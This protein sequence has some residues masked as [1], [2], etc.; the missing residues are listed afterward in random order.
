MLGSR[1]SSTGGSPTVR[2]PVL[3]RGHLVPG[4]IRKSVRT[5]FEH[6]PAHTRGHPAPHRGTARKVPSA[7]TTS[8]GCSGGSAHCRRQCPRLVDPLSEARRA[9]S[10]SGPGERRRRTHS[11]C[12]SRGAMLRPVR[13]E[14]RYAGSE[15]D[16]SVVAAGAVPQREP[17]RDQPVDLPRQPRHQLLGRHRDVQPVVLDARD[18]SAG[19]DLD[20]YLLFLT[21]AH[22]GAVPGRDREPARGTNDTLRSAAGRP[23]S[24]GRGGRGFASRATRRTSLCRGRPSSGPL[25][26]V[27]RTAARRRRAP[28][29]IPVTLSGWRPRRARPSQPANR[30]RM[31]A[32]SSR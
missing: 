3:P 21:R 30:C 9:L 32:T 18:P 23:R 15:A 10:R 8:R 29:M 6:S 31:T 11:R 28:T 4:P 2:S 26:M 27:S 25:P 19:S 5:T 20:Y 12:K 17:G 24:A 14:G 16:Q 22:W 7:R 1:T 13:N